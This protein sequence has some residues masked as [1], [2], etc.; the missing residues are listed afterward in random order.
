MAGVLPY[1]LSSL[2]PILRAKQPFQQIRYVPGGFFEIV[3]SRFEVRMRQTRLGYH[4]ASR[5]HP[6]PHD[7]MPLEIGELFAMQ[8]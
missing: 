6:Q 1:L 8:I 3:R 2:F 7:A 5:T 4:H